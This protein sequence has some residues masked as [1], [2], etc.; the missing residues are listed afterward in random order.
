MAS[1]AQPTTPAP[2][3]PN[4]Y[5]ILCLA[6]IVGIIIL[7]IRSC[8]TRRQDIVDQG[9]FISSLSDSLTTYKNKDSSQTATISVLQ[10]TS[11]GDFFGLKIKDSQIVILQGLVKQYQQKLKAGSSVTTATTETTVK[12]DTKPTVSDYDS[13]KT[14][15]IVYVYPK[16][17]DS[18][19]SEWISYKATMTKDK[20]SLDLKVINKYAVIVGYEKRKPYVDIVNF[21]PYSSTKILR[22]YQVIIPKQKVWGIGFSSGMALGTNFKIQPYLGIGI[23]Y[24]I[25]R[26]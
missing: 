22:S 2:K 6:L 16:Y 1:I 10:T 14:G 23:S 21:N 3:E 7:S 18:L 19:Y 11:A 9:S 5:K 25:I 8:S 4:I 26:F 20:A 13:I 12:H 15:S 24:N 17:T